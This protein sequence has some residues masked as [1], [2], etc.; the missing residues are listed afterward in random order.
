[1]FELKSTA[2]RSGLD[3]AW[4]K[5]DKLAWGTRKSRF[6]MPSSAIK[7]CLVPDGL[8]C[9]R[10]DGVPR[11]CSKRGRQDVPPLTSPLD[12]HS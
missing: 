2:P 9:R 8:L 10:P 3:E 4:S 11:G 1:M 6:R 7:G 12:S 5:L